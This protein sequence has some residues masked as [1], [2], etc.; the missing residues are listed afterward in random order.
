MKLGIKP[1]WTYNLNNQMETAFFSRI[2]IQKS[3][4]GLKTLFKR[5]GW[6]FKNSEH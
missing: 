2:Y 4:L 1:D 3:C 5:G 6:K